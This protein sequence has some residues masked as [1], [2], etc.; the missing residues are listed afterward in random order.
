MRRHQKSSRF[1]LDWDEGEE[2]P[3]FKKAKD[4]LLG[5]EMTPYKYTV[6]NLMAS[7]WSPRRDPR[8][9]RKLDGV[10]PDELHD[11][12]E[13]FHRYPSS[14][15]I[16]EDVLKPLQKKGFVKVFK[17]PGSEKGDAITKKGLR[18][19]YPEMPGGRDENGRRKVTTGL[20]HRLRVCA[21]ARVL[22]RKGFFFYPVFH[23]VSKHE[24]G[25]WESLMASPSLRAS[26]RDS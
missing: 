13:D 10:G 11:K 5:A 20:I 16:I 24:F 3:M 1:G 26:S 25:E 4:K 22:A 12:V 6:M 15:D 2:T 18:F 14:V 8:N 9:L 23:W 21:G 19:L 17:P 7:R